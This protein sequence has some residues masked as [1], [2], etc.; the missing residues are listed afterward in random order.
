[1]TLGRITGR[2]HVPSFAR[3]P[4]AAEARTIGLHALAFPRPEPWAPFLPRFA[5]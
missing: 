3:W 5:R 4:H 1:M 2:N